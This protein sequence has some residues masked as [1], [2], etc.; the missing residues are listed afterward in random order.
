M[1]APVVADVDHGRV[2]YRVE[3]SGNQSGLHLNT[4]FDAKIV[5]LGFFPGLDPD[6]ITNM[7]DAGYRGMVLE[8]YGAGGMPYR[9]R[10]IAAAVEGVAGKIPI[11]L[12]TQVV[13]DGVHLGAYE[14][15]QKALDTGVISACDMTR[16]A[17]ITKMI[18]ALGQS[19]DP[20]AV[21]EIM[22]TNY[23]GEIDSQYS[24]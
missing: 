13:R 8:S 11:L 5:V 1:N 4:E 14:V 21:K 17:G 16:E 19:R 7:F 10:D 12:A 6:V 24:L 20:E 9:R 22:H 2:S 3:L 18:W 23:A 15:G